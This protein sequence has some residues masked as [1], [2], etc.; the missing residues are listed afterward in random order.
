ML[1]KRPF[2][3]LLIIYL[4]FIALTGCSNPAVSDNTEGDFDNYSLTDKSSKKWLFLFY[5][6]GDDSSSNL[7][8]NLKN[9]I[10]AISRGLSECN[11]A[12]VK[13]VRYYTI[14]EE[15]PHTSVQHAKVEVEKISCLEDE[16]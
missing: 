11:A 5:F 2:F 16:S 1:K 14:K 15:A 6:C 10:A 4:I 9:N 13:A 12:D 7:Y 3:L 8:A